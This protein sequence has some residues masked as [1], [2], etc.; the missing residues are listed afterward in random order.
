MARAT[1]AP[2][3]AGLQGKFG[4]ASFS[5]GKRGVTNMRP[6]V[7][8]TNPRTA[9]QVAVRTAQTKSAQ[10]FKNFST[11]QVAAW[12]AYAAT[13]PQVS[14]KTGAK[15]TVQGIN[16]YCALADKFQLITPGATP[17]TTPPTS[18]FQGDSGVTVTAGSGT[19]GQ[20]SFVASAANSANVRTELL[21]QPL[22]G[23]N[24]TPTARGYR[25]KT[26][27][28]FVAGSLTTNVAVPAGWYACAV[29]FVSPV[30][31]QETALV[32]LGT[33]TVG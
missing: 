27:T 28:T 21:L 29:R 8:P 22:K 4:T 20:V 13:L 33:V 32:P 9:A 26:Y 17:P 30:T 24:R 7:T 3:L 2:I 10:T 11:A 18:A 23:K 25:T 16:A 12:K 19:A 6:R 31:G 5:K 14:R 1:L 15:I